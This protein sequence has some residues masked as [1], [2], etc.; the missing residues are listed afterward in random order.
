MSLFSTD[1]AVIDAG[2]QRLSIMSLSYC[3]SAFMDCTIAASR[4]LGKTGIPSFIVIMGSCVFRIIWL[5]TVFAW[6][7]TIPSLFLLYTFSWAI[8]A[9]AEIAYF[10]HIYKKKPSVI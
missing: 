5:C 7:R 3:I 6:F 9:A 4:G 2:M 10:I 8:T 1:A